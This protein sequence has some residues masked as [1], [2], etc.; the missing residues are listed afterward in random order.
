M[1]AN[2]DKINK[3]CKKAKPCTHLLVPRECLV[4]CKMFSRRIILQLSFVWFVK[5][6]KIVFSMTENNSPK[7]GNIFLLKKG[8]HI[9]LPPHY[10]TSPLFHQSHPSH[11]IFLFSVTFSCNETNKEKTSLEIVFSMKNH[12]LKTSNQTEPRR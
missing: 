6:S 1:Y 3:F 10:L 8:K 4:G 12:S 2:N 7:G 9:F 11:S 5:G